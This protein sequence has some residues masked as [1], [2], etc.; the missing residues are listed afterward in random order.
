MYRPVARNAKARARRPAARY[1]RG[2][3]LCIPR[4]GDR[5][6][7]LA[8]WAFTLHRGD[9]TTEAAD[10]LTGASPAAARPLPARAVLAAGTVLRDAVHH[11]GGERRVPVRAVVDAGRVRILEARAAWGMRG[12]IAYSLHDLDGARLGSWRTLG[13]LRKRAAELAPEHLERG[14]RPARG[15][16]PGED[17]WATG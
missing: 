17:D 6:R 14:G 8:D 13:S 9:A 11:H 7:L 15:D 5:L 12:G 4:P 3:R 1:I 16:R 2:M 10:R